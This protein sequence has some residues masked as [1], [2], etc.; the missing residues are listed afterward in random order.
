[1]ASLRRTLIGVA[2][3]LVSA[4]GASAEV[5]RVAQPKLAS[6]L[7]G[8]YEGAFAY[9]SS[10]TTLAL[11]APGGAGVR[12]IAIGRGCRPLDASGL[13]VLVTCQDALG[14]D[15]QPPE[16]VDVTDGTSTPLLAGPL[17]PR[18][19]FT[20]LGARWALG[21]RTDEDRRGQQA[22]LVDRRTGKTTTRAPGRFDLDSP[23]ATRVRPAP[24]R[25]GSSVMFGDVRRSLRLIT[26]TRRLVFEDDGRR[27]ELATCRVRCR[28]AQLAGDVAV[29]SQGADVHRFD[30]KTRATKTWFLD[31]LRRGGRVQLVAQRDR[32]VAAVPMAGGR[33]RLLILR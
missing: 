8:S 1:M 28:G 2:L 31:G 12:I 19:S 13:G 10:P 11:G 3:L 21:R 15:L 25:R 14:D 18:T 9:K 29:W 7:V 22:V 4:P 17:P 24:Y 27:R 20:R 26:R 32:V 5:R 30:T 16:V 33:W 23:T 6:P